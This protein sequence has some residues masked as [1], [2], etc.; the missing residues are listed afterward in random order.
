MTATH[1][2]SPDPAGGPAATPQAASARSFAVGCGPCDLAGEPLRQ[3]GEADQL[4]AVHD[5]LRHR[6]EPTAEVRC[7]PDPDPYASTPR[8][9]S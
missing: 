8:S 6:G 5:H 4:A 1:A 9:R 3:A 7:C 2:P